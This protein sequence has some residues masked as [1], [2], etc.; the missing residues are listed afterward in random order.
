MECDG[1]K[2]W[3]NR[4]IKEY[5]KDNGRLHIEASENDIEFFPDYPEL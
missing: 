4:K 3:I 2:K 1:T 5:Q